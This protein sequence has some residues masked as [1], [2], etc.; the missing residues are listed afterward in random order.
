LV[1]ILVADDNPTVRHSLR[2]LL[3]Q[4]EGWQVCGEAA[5]GEEAV[6]RFQKTKPDL[7]VLDF[8]MPAMNGL[9]AARRIIRISPA[10]PILLV[11]L[12]MSEQLAAEARK[13]GIRGTCA[14]A[15]LECLIEAASTLLRDGTYFAS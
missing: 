2:A 11:T 6:Q 4:H 12:Y 1:R 9:E 10:T 3:E 8:R 14:K 13:A 7:I 5:D 15:D